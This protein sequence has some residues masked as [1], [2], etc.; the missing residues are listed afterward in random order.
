MKA[1]FFG[2]Y[3][4]ADYYPVCLSR[5]VYALLAGTSKIYEKWVDILHFENYAFLCRDYLAESLAA[6]TGKEVNAIS[7]EE[8]LL[9]NGIFLPSSEILSRIEKLDTNE[10]LSCDGEL[11]AGRI[12]KLDS[13]ALDEIADGRS[14][15]GLRTEEIEVRRFS[16]LWDIINGNG[17]IIGTEFPA[18]KNLSVE[19]GAALKK[20]DLIDSKNIAVLGNV[21]IGPS[22]VIDASQGP[23]I[24]DRNV[25]IEPFT[26]L[27]GPVY[28]GPGT[29]IVG[30]RIRGGCSIGPACRVG[31]EVEATIMIG[32]CNKYHEGFLGHG[33]LGQWVNLGAL[34]TNSDLK[35][36]Y[37]NI[38]V[39]LPGGIVESGSMKVGCFI[40][41]HTKTGIGT[42]LNTGITVGFSCNL[43]GAGLFLEKRIRSFSWGTPGKLVDYRPEKA[44]RTAA[45]SM[46]RRDV[47]FGPVQAR[48]FARIA[49]VDSDQRNIGS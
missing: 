33:Y 47:E 31:G 32:C 11:V 23:V 42:M 13:R 4:H 10:G 24:I 37:S 16:R 30:G 35:N 45:A 3:H 26:Y 34:T 46:A 6:E 18:F 28:I 15:A 36:N 7:D 2:D 1:I 19:P 43:F 12:K 9:I 27:Q 21:S 40:G 44:A 14:P 17:E 38:N 39:E 25:T 22:L 49:E 8:A 20:A 29:R 5:P 48:L 41:D